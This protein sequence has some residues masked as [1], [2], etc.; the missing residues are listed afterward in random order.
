ARVGFVLLTSGIL[1]SEL[2]LFAQ[3]TFFWAGWGMMHGHYWHLF[4]ASA[5]MP[6]GVALLLLSGMARR[7]AQ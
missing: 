4:I 2:L 7:R 6:A 3:G 5:L 1:A